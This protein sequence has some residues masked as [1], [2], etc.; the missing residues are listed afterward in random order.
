[1]IAAVG[2]LLLAVALVAAVVS[3][4]LWVRVARGHDEAASARLAG[5][6]V[7]P[8][9]LG[10]V[11][12]MELALLTDDYSIEYVASH[13]SS[14]TP[15]A[16]RVSALWGGLDGSLLLWLLVLSGF[17][18]LVG[19]GRAARRRASGT[20]VEAL[21]PVAAAVTS[22]VTAAFAAVTLVAARPFSR[23]LPAPADGAGPN[24]LLVDH[25]AMLVH[26]PLLYV[27]YAGL[28]VPFA[29]AVAALV[30]GRTGPGWLATVR[31][32]SVIAWVSLTAG[33]TLGAWWSYAVLGW[34]GYW[35]WDPVENASLVPWLCTT[36]LLHVVMARRH[37]PALGPWVAGLA[38]AGFLLVVTGTFLTRS[39][40]VA[41]VHSFT[42]SALGPVL[43]GILAVGVVGVAGLLVW[44]GDRLRPGDAGAAG[45]F[46]AR[47]SLL[48]AGAALVGGLGLTVL[49]GTVA[50]AVLRAAGAGEVS[51][52]RPFF[53]RVAVPVVLV[54]LVLMVL[55]P[56]ARWRQDRLPRL[57]AR[58]AV[59]ALV[60]AVT[61]CGLGF[62]GAKGVLAVGTI[63]LA[64]AV[65]TGTV[66]ALVRGRGTP[67]AGRG[68]AGGHLA[69]A[70]FALVAV[71]VAA[72][73][74]W[75]TTT[76]ATVRV[77]DV[78]RVASSTVRLDGVDRHAD[79]RR[80]TTAARLTVLD[81]GRRAGSAAA[82][83]VFYPGRDVTVPTPAVSSGL[84]GDLYVTLLAVDPQAGTAT[85]RV[86]SEPLVGLLWLGGALAAVGGALVVLPGRRRRGRAVAEVAAPSTP[87]AAQLVR[88]E[89]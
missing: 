5:G 37:N 77:G 58:A 76:E 29:Y 53:D 38:G 62:L 14:A 79:Q 66:L 86:T 56:L 6:L 81:D 20:G 65:L 68:G 12:A 22:T 10:A 89:R 84:G 83:L 49:L 55:A 46:P 4:A 69:H 32:W 27:G 33:I 64:A 45:G 13:S 72:T 1:M 2:T 9:A 41:S 17:T 54:L 23:L 85:L 70:G 30:A 28:V 18:V 44:R 82:A 67:L 16:Y 43:L 57:L 63:A 35:A 40:V 73:S 25:P 24:P 88:G 48:V 11:A 75:S 31:T 59:P 74:A 15:V 42:P 80:M 61:T 52:G 51:V 3:A 47:E 78:V 34:G 7:L 8:G 26:P 87:V 36:A 19:S 21:L 50:P 60:A 39:G 71:G